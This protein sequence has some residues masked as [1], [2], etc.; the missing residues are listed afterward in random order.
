MR[1]LDNCKFDM[2]DLTPI[3]EKMRIKVLEWGGFYCGFI[4]TN[5]PQEFGTGS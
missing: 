1:N 2:E 4:D 3:F 5:E